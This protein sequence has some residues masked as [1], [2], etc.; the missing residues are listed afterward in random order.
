MEDRIAGAIQFAAR[1]HHGQKD[2][3]GAPY[4][5]HP[6]RVMLACKTED[7][8]I[9]AVLHD[10]VEDCGACLVTIRHLYGKHIEDAVNALTRR[11]VE[12]Y[13]A[14]LLYTSPSPR[15]RG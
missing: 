10:T 11:E 6:L 5:L 7:E 9:V 2:K 13:S 15:D 12:S 3:A 4:I 8:R 14:C 1:L